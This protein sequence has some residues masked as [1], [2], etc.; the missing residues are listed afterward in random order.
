MITRNKQILAGCIVLILAGIG[1]VAFS[2]RGNQQ[3]TAESTTG[4]QAQSDTDQGANGTDSAAVET[5]EEQPK[6]VEQPPKESRGVFSD[7]Y[8]ITNVDVQVHEVIYDGTSFLPNSL[9]IKAG[10]I[11]FFKNES[12]KSFWPASDPHPSHTAYPEFDAKASL[13]AGATFDF[14]FIKVGTWGFHDHLRP[15]ATGTII[16]TK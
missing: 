15:A 10:D 14:K 13:A 1:Y 5:T 2:Q 16:V 8:D 9:E 3:D 12:A 7:E 11:V 6:P 4:T